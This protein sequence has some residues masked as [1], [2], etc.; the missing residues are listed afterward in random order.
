MTQYSFSD[1]S[2]G[3][4]ELHTHPHLVSLRHVKGDL[5]PSA[6]GLDLSQNPAFILLIT[7][8]KGR[9]AINEK[10]YSLSRDQLLLIPAKAAKSFS[11]DRNF[12]LEFWQIG[13]SNLHLKG[14]TSGAL[15][16]E[17]ESPVISVEKN[18]TFL[19][20]YI[21]IFHELVPRNDEGLLSEAIDHQL[22]SFIACIRYTIQSRNQLST[23]NQEYNLGLRIKE[24]IDD[25]FREDMTLTSMAD[26]LNVNVYY[27]S[28]TFKKL[29][30]YS[31]IQYMI[32]RRIGEAQNLL[33]TTDDSI[34]DIAMQCGYNNA[35][36]FQASFSHIVGMPPG[37][38]R[39]TWK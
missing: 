22:A 7:N 12:P 36:Y 31:P 15:L 33:L 13:I 2:R 26:A 28:H 6:T 20:N 4:F 18:H 24:Y 21:R 10:S 17:E 16:H 38:Y 35:N 1:D 11:S 30:G 3:I 8:G 29:I 27:L 19:M 37:K 25:H 14:M 39:K 5:R 9:A 23:K 34:T 32:H